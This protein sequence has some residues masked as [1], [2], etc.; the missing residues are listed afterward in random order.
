MLRT[1]AAHGLAEEVYAVVN[2]LVGIMQEAPNLRIYSA[3]ILANI[4]AEHGSA[5]EV[6]RLLAEMED[7]GILLDDAT[8]HS[9]LKV[10]CTV[11]GPNNDNLMGSRFSLYTRTVFFVT[12]W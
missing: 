5:A 7:Q 1:K 8:Y 4:S 10:C 6:E 12:E 3:L 11:T 9:V 2:Q